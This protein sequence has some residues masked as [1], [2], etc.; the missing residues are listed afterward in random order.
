MT[1]KKR[2]I[3]CLSALFLAFLASFVWAWYEWG[4]GADHGA[5]RQD[6]VKVSLML[7]GQT[8]LSQDT[9]VAVE[10][11]GTLTLQ[12]AQEDTFSFLLISDGVVVEDGTLAPKEQKT[13]QTKPF[14][15]AAYGF[16]LTLFW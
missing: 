3:L 7:N 9:A 15:P 6:F 16:G 14:F 13:L 5:F 1:A 4:I 8:L 11:N 10:Q 2:C 12:N